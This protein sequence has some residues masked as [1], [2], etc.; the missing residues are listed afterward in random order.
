MADEHIDKVL[1]IAKNRLIFRKS[2]F[3]VGAAKLVQ[4]F[5]IFKN[6]TFLV[7]PMQKF[8]IFKNG[9]FLVM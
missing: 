9:D 6:R 8:L 2:S 5:I 4:F 7:Q 1:E 3:L